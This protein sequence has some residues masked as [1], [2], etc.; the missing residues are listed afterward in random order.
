LQLSCDEIETLT[1]IDKE[2]NCHS[3]E[4]LIAASKPYRKRVACIIHD[5]GGASQIAAMMLHEWDCFQWRV[6][7]L[8]GA[9]GEDYFIQAP[10]KSSLVVL[11][12]P[13]Q[14]MSE[15]ECWRPDIVLTNPGWGEFPNRN[16]KAVTDLQAHHIS[17]IEHFHDYRQRF[18][19]PDQNW[20]N[21]CPETLLVNHPAG[22]EIAGQIPVSMI[23]QLK[24][25]ATALM[26]HELS[27]YRKAS[28]RQPSALLFLSQVVDGN[29]R[30][31][32]RFSYMGEFEPLVLNDLVAH[33]STISDV[34]GIETVKMRCH[35]S[36]KSAPSQVIQ[37]AIQACGLTYELEM[38]GQVPFSRSLSSARLVV[39][40][41]SMALYT[42][43]LC[44]LPA[45]SIIPPEAG[46]RSLPLPRRV[47]FTA[48]SELLGGS[49]AGLV[50]TGDEK[51]MT[52]GLSFKDIIAA[53]ETEPCCENSC[54]H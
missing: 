46:E 19:F 20:R 21:N 45:V 8:Q 12:D 9:P 31:D 39:G 3:G 36:R 34:F 35:P 29:G 49:L 13:S 25:Y 14:L 44:G 48:C 7:T 10:L 53:I 26:R 52:E 28:G 15:L 51:Q 42:A 32:G 30:G 16:L 22:V 38:G 17:F 23:Y 40:L 2:M 18:G 50:I 54:H 5:A 41:N 27:I 6:Y 24:D 11:S 43:F 37:E 33:L 47:S 4:S 1:V